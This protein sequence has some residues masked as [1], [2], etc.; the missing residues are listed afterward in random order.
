MKTKAAATWT[1]C[2]TV[3]AAVFVTSRAFSDVPAPIV[4]GATGADVFTAG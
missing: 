4:S 1:T 3:L 2:A